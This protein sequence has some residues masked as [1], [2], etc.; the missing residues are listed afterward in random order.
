MFTRNWYKNIARVIHYSYGYDTVNYNGE[1]GTSQSGQGYANGACIQLGYK[2]E[3]YAYIPSMWYLRSSLSQSS[4]V[5]LGTGNTPATID[6][7]RLAGD[8]VS[9]FTYNSNVVSESD[10]DGLTLTAN[11]TITN[12]SDAEIVIAEIGIIQNTSVG[13]KNANYKMLLERTVLES[14]ITI[15]AGG[16]GQVTYTI[17]LNYLPA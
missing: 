14:P 1:I 10:N 8:I 5:F 17:R 6:D 3:S 13:T 7:Y 9:G 4:G 11:Y 16:V 2:N 15:P 12:T